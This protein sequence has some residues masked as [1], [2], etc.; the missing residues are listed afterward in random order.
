MCTYVKL[1]C[2]KLN[3][4][5]HWNCVLI[6]SWIVWNRTFWHLILYKQKTIL[7]LNWIV[8]NRTVYMYKNGFGINDLQW[9]MCH[10]TKPNQICPLNKTQTGNTTQALGG[11]GS[12]NNEE[13]SYIPQSTRTGSLWPGGLLSYPGHSLGVGQCNLQP[14]LT[15]WKDLYLQ[16]VPRLKLNL[17]IQEL[18][19]LA[20]SSLI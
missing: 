7:I 2:L 8:W 13:V 15:W 19:F 20:F 17:S 18:V 9:L 10:K 1:N 11:P 14:L 3:C 6:L 16:K 12:N 5:W 4:F